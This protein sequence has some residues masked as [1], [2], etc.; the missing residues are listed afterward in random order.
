M[1]YVK[2]VR[3]LARRDAIKINM[4]GE[5]QHTLIVEGLA[6]GEFVIGDYVV[7]EEYILT[8]NLKHKS[9][10]VN[11]MYKMMKGSSSSSIIIM[12]GAKQVVNF[13][14]CVFEIPYVTPFKFPFKFSEMIVFKS[15]E[16]EQETSIS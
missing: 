1:V 5:G 2:S 14:G 12:S 6:T 13:R 10:I 3:M 9:P 15:S 11:I 7:W 4:E 16:S 8:F